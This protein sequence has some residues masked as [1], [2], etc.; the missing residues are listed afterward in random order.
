MRT[1]RPHMPGGYGIALGPGPLSWEDALHRLREARNYWLCTS[2]P[3]G[4]PH[5]VPIWAVWVE[6][7]LWFGTDAGS[8]KARNLA[9]RPHCVIHLE[10]GDETLIVEGEA[11]VLPSVDTADEAYYAK[12]GTRMSEA[13]G[14]LAFF[15][16]RPVRA[17][18]WRE[19]DFPVSASRWS[20]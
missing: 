3:E 5:S 4:R 13:P 9:A 15:A 7:G 12:Y 8:R 16:V 20:F 14:E 11:C 17:M 2:S 10:S 19:Q 1:D 18:A 6:D